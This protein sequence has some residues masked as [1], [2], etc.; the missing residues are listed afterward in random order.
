MNT[1]CDNEE[2]L[3]LFYG[4]F[5]SKYWIENFNKDK[6]E[7]LFNETTIFYKR[8]DEHKKWKI[9]PGKKIRPLLL[10]KLKE[11]LKKS[12][13]LEKLEEIMKENHFIKEKL[14]DRIKN[15]FRF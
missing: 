14:L 5:Q 11:K 4:Y 9:F 15:H 7:K 6:Y 1:D 8:I 10:E 2:W 13:P 12:I 3:E